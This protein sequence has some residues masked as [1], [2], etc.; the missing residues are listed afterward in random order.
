MILYFILFLLVL[1]DNSYY[2]LETEVYTDFCLFVILFFITSLKNKT[3]ELS[4]FDFFLLDLTLCY[5][6]DLSFGLRQMSTQF[7]YLLL[8]I[9]LF[10]RVTNL[11]HFT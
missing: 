2:C 4:E 7:F 8:V 6:L 10:V 9:I 3:W 1:R 11:S 5:I